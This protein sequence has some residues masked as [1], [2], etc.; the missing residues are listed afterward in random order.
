M[1][2]KTHGE[3]IAATQQRQE[4]QID[5]PQHL[6]AFR[7]C[8]LHMLG[9]SEHLHLRD[10][11]VGR[12]LPVDIGIYLRVTRMLMI[13]FHLRQVEHR[14]DAVYVL[15]GRHDCA[16]GPKILHRIDRTQ[17]SF[18][19]RSYMMLVTGMPAMAYRR[20]SD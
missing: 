19:A 7:C 15:G 11:D 3:H 5:L 6:A 13:G 17:L 2:G 20:I 12:T 4:N 9:M 1:G 8:E 10:F 16:V 18:T 14:S